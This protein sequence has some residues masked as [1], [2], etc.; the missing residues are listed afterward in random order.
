MVSDPAIKEENN[1]GDDIKDVFEE[2]FISLEDRYDFG[3]KDNLTIKLCV[4]LMN[5]ECNGLTG[6]CNGLTGECNGLTGE[7]NGLTG[8]CN[9]LYSASLFFSSYIPISLTPYRI[10]L[11]IDRTLKSQ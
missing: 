3:S 2:D 10:L 4:Y 8:E 9:G 6:E 1:E 11:I 7:C 5:G